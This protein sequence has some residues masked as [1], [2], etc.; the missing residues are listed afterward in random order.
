M[1][2]MLGHLFTICPCCPCLHLVHCWVC[3]TYTKHT[4]THAHT[5]SIV[6]EVLSM[7]SMWIY[8]IS[9]MLPDIQCVCHFG[10]YNLTFFFHIS[11]KIRSFTRTCSPLELPSAC[12][13]GINKSTGETI[14]A[15]YTTCD[16]NG[17]N[18]D[19]SFHHL[20]DL[21]RRRRRK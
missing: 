18:A 2:D 15:C 13:P 12:L 17:C 3:T 10:T 5:L 11:G 21:L 20:I 6:K 19:R 16:T 9:Q 7:G 1:Y 8:R 14:Q 4:W